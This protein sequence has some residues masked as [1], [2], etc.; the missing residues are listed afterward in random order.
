MDIESSKINIGIVKIILE[1]LNTPLS[2]ES[3]RCWVSPITYYLSA[4]VL[5][6]KNETVL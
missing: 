2:G 5:Q 1:W 6:V 4:I 3:H